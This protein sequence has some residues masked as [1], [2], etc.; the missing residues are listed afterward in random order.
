MKSLLINQQQE[1]AERFLYE[2]Q[3]LAQLSRFALLKIASLKRCES[4]P[5]IS[6]KIREDIREYVKASLLDYIPAAEVVK[7]K[8]F[9]CSFCAN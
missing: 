4:V 3:H 9:E 6:R 8:R 5:G 7:M 1:L 2:E